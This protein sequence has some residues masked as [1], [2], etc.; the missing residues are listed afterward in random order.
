MGFSSNLS[1][2]TDRLLVSMESWLYRRLIMYRLVT[3]RR[4]YNLRDDLE[5]EALPSL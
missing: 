2:Y 4:K 1:S 3:E 5:R